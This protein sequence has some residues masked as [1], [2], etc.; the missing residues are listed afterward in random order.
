MPGYLRHPPAAP[1][2]GFL[3]RSSSTLHRRYTGLRNRAGGLAVIQ[4]KRCFLV[5]NTLNCSKEQI[6]PVVSVDSVTYY[7]ADSIEL[8]KQTAAVSSISDT[9]TI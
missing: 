6:V 3:K 8:V 9:A 1:S 4:D 5:G 2:E 7:I